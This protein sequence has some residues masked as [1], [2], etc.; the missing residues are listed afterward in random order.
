MKS[1]VLMRKFGFLQ[2]AITGVAFCGLLAFAGCRTVASV[3]Q[4]LIEQ[5]KSAVKEEVAAAQ[6]P[7]RI[8]A[9][10]MVQSVEAHRAVVVVTVYFDNPNLFEIPAP[11]IVYNYSL[12]RNSF[13]RGIVN[14]ASPLAGSAVTPVSFRLIVNYTDL[15]RS[16]PRL[17]NLNQVD[18]LVTLSYELGDELVN[19]EIAGVLPLRRF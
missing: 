7:Q 9:S 18:G 11:R 8:G 15:F 4:P 14:D 10:M 2:I 5:E 16:F 12:N 13:I 1:F 6:L 3:Q 17:R 19:L